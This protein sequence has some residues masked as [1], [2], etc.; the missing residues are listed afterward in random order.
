MSDE[1]VL[2][3][4][5][6]LPV[7][8]V[9]ATAQTVEV[10]PLA[11]KTKASFAERIADRIALQKWN[12]FTAR[13]RAIEAYVEDLCGEVD[14]LADNAHRFLSMA[15]VHNTS[16]FPSFLLEQMEGFI[17]AAEEQKEGIWDKMVDN[18]SLDLFVDIMWLERYHKALEK[19]KMI[20]WVSEPEKKRS[21][22][23]TLFVDLESL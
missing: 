12:A 18:Q 19:I 23:V 14:E 9:E 5:S 17:N 2:E 4:G 3:E 16:G 7:E 21:L 8:T 11:E 13:Q 15:K 22:L 6:D 1:R 10:L 20:T